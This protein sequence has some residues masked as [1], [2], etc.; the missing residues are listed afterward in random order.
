MRV[1]S[2]YCRKLIC[3]G[4]NVVKGTKALISYASLISCCLLLIKKITYYLMFLLVE[5]SINIMIIAY[6]LGRRNRVVR[7]ISSF[8]QLVE[9]LHRKN[10]EKQKNKLI[11]TIHYASKIIKINIR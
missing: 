7:V 8:R 6:L 1:V 10:Y 3:L 9:T 4:I 11:I 5:N 2:P